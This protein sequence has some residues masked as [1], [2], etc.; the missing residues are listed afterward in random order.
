MLYSGNG[1]EES[2]V[3]ESEER[4]VEEGCF[5]RRVLFPFLFFDATF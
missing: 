1:S 4:E 2:E 5:V 3:N